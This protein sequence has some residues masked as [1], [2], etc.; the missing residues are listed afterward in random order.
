VAAHSEISPVQPDALFACLAAPLADKRAKTLALKGFDPRALASWSGPF[1][2]QHDTLA[3]YIAERAKVDEEMQ[4]FTNLF[5][6]MLA[7]SSVAA[8]DADTDCPLCGS[9]AALAPARIAFI[10][11]PVA[12]TELSQQAQADA[13]DALTQMRAL[14]KG[15]IDG[16]GQALPLFIT[17]SPRFRR[18]KG[19]RVMPIE[20]D[21]WCSR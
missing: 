7:L 15:A 1:D 21:G 6:E 3:C 8:A 11:E 19:F 9:E 18:A 4:R 12:N 10:R 20:S 5:R 14:V 2:T 13:G 16:I 17:N